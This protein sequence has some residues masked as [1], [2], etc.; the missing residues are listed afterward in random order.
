MA[1]STNPHE[2]SSR[3][4]MS[5]RQFRDA[6]FVHMI[7]SLLTVL[8]HLSAAAFCLFTLTQGMFYRGATPDW[9]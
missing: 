3:Q 8:F 1:G 6:P 4:L 9:P 7:T 5:A 2:Y